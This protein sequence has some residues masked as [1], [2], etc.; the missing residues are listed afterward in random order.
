M[1][2]RYEQTARIWQFSEGFQ[3]FFHMLARY[4]SYPLVDLQERNLTQDNEDM[5]LLLHEISR[6][7]MRQACGFAIAKTEPIQAQ[8]AA[9]RHVFF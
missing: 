7:Q 2:G 1:L 9:L 6:M 5:Q 8:F 4:L 3:S